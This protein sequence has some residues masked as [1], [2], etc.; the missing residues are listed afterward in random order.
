MYLLI[1]QHSFLSQSAF[2]QNKQVKKNK[3]IDYIGNRWREEDSE[4]NKH[5]KMQAE[6][7]GAEMV[8]WS[9]RA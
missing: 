6:E 1:Y 9:Q 8:D 2:V 4:R 3:L 5:R 7:M